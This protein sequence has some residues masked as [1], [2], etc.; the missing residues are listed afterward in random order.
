[1]ELELTQ[2]D[3]ARIKDSTHN[4]QAANESLKRV[5]PRK[6]PNIADIESCLTEAD[7]TLRGLL[8]KKGSSSSLV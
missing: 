3:Q 1:M 8:R 6:I 7:Q 4:I 2:E 5:D